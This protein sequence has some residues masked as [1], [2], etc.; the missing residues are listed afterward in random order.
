MNAHSTVLY[1]ESW[2]LDSPVPAIVD[3]LSTMPPTLKQVFIEHNFHL[4][5]SGYE[6]SPY[7]VWS[8]FIPLASRC[9]S[10]SISLHISP[11]FFLRKFGNKIVAGAF[12]SSLTDYNVLTPYVQSGAVVISEVIMS[13]F[14]V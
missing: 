3:I 6:R 12:L 9:S 14:C 11:H 7:P 2:I 1:D 13:D 8:Q 5:G 10:A 4:L